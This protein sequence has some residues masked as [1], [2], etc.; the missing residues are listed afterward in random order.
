MPK[1][2]WIVMFP[3]MPGCAADESCSAEHARKN[4]FAPY[5]SKISV[6]EI[7][8]SGNERTRMK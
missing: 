5:F 1:Y 7:S 6:A 2:A 8:K 3:A 4:Q